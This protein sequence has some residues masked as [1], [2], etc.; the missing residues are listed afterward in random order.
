MGLGAY[1]KKTNSLA[2]A[3][4]TAIQAKSQVN[5]KVDPIDSQKEAKAARQLADKQ[6]EKEKQLKEMTFK[7]CAER[8]IEAMKAEW[9]NPKHRQQWTNTLTTYAYPCIGN[10]PVNE[11]EIEH[12]RQC[13]DPIWYEKTET[14]TRVRQRIESVIGYAI[15]HNYRQ[16]ANPAVWKGMLSNFYPNPSKVKGRKYEEAGIEKHHNAL[17]Y[18]EMPSFMTK[19]RQMEG[20]APLALRF[21]ILTAARTSE[22]RFATWDEFDLERKEWN[23]PKARMKARHAHRVALPD[24][25]VELFKSMPHMGEYVFPGGKIGKPMSN[26]GMA[27][28]LKRMQRQDITVHGFR[29]SF[30]DCIGEETGFPHR[31]A[32]FALAHALTNEAEK[33]YARGDMLK[34]RFKMMNVW[35]SYVDSKADSIAYLS[36][37]A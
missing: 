15:A 37:R 5:S 20:I 27:A 24:A 31:L 11:I 30:R 18:R 2:M 32:E 14:A 16:T 3:R 1:D 28:V 29:S 23:I 4:K 8:Y 26:G 25:A 13:L 17:N 19:L 22:V 33:A 7:V 10:M 9:S 21:T 35:A 34:K 6:A 12:V 36:K